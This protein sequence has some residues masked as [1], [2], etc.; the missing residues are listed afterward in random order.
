MVVDITFHKTPPQQFQKVRKLQQNLHSIIITFY[1]LEGAEKVI[2][3]K[4]T[5][6]LH[7]SN[8]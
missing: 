1:D 6:T 5:K 8:D 4:E 7:V 2:P 3:V